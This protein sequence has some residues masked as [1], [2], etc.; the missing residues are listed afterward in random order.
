MSAS[1]QN[2]F[3]VRLSISPRQITGPFQVQDLVKALQD[4]V[5]LWTDLCWNATGNSVWKRI[6]DVPEF[7]SAMV[8]LPSV[9]KLEEYQNMCVNALSGDSVKSE[10]KI[11]S[12]GTR[13][14]HQE[15]HSGFNTLPELTAPVYLQVAGSEFGPLSIVEFKKLLKNQKFNAPI[16]MW[17]KGLRAWFPMEDLNLSLF[18]G[19]DLLIN[20][21][22]YRRPIPLYKIK[23]GREVRGAKRFGLVAM[24]YR[25]GPRGLETIGSCGDISRTGV[26]I[27]LTQPLQAKVDAEFEIQVVPLSISGLGGITL[28]VAMRWYNQ[29]EMRAGFEFVGSHESAPSFIKLLEYLAQSEP[30]S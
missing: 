15:T 17:Y 7:A 8:E 3:V 9:Q 6:F 12:D 11:S 30:V 28:T 24:I 19:K 10:G 26:Q 2:Y 14:I 16:Y 23:Q 20:V 21:N 5:F 13:L 18:L 4:G 25:K 29:A 27:W 22:Q 1:E